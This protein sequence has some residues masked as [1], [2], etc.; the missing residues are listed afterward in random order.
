MSGDLL[1]YAVQILT[2]YKQYCNLGKDSPQPDIWSDPFT[3]ALPI[4]SL[5]WL[6]MFVAVYMIC[7]LLC[8]DNDLSNVVLV[9]HPDESCD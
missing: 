3:E 4:K 1:M 2:S 6:Q 7:I 8:Y 9:L 5:P